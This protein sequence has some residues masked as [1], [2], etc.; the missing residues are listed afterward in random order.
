MG[1]DLCGMGS[2]AK[3]RVFPNIFLLV[4]R[5]GLSYV[6]IKGMDDGNKEGR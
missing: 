6:D 2:C 3:K 1:L 5:L 4:V